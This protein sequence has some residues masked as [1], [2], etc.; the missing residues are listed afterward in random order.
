MVPDA[1]HWLF[2]DVDPSAIDPERHR[3]YIFERVMVRGDWDAMRWLLK[4]FSDELLADFLARRGSRLPP[5]D[6]AFWS[7]I[8]RGERVSQPG[9]ARPS[10]A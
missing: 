4:T 10:W 3:D 9:G 5:R 6:R 8:V 1:L 2:W 7:W